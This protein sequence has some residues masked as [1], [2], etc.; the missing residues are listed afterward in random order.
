MDNGILR[1]SLY[2]LMMAYNVSQPCTHSMSPALEERGTTA[3][4]FRFTRSSVS[5]PGVVGKTPDRRLDATESAMIELIRPNNCITRS[6]CFR[7]SFP[8][9]KYLNFRPLEPKI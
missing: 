8:F 7:S 6:S 4:R 2:P 3:N 9:N 1:G 5:I